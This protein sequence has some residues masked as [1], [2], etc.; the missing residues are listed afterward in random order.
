MV[1]FGG[2]VFKVG[3]IYVVNAE[4]EY[5]IYK[6]LKLEASADNIFHIHCKC[7]WSKSGDYSLFTISSKGWYMY[8][9]KKLKEDSLEYLL[10]VGSNNGHNSR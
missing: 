5:L 1:T 10:R 7:L 8:N 9:A 2:V 4:G 3:D 6:L